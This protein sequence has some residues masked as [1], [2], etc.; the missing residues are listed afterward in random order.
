MPSGRFSDPVRRG[1]AKERRSSL[2]RWEGCWER[3]WRPCNRGFTFSD[4][5]DPGGMAAAVARPALGSRV[6]TVGHG[7]ADGEAYGFGGP[8]DAALFVLRKRDTQRSLDNCAE[9]DK[10]TGQCG[11]TVDN[12]V[13]RAGK[14]VPQGKAHND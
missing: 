4:V 3:L 8:L 2:G 10:Q 5:A 7:S 13:A 1:T 6:V 12:V 11:P 14:E 9:E